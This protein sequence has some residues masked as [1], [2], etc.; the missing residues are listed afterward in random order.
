MSAD[1][2]R[3]WGADAE[4]GAHRGGMDVEGGAHGGGVEAV[5]GQSQTRPAAGMDMSM[6]VDVA[7][8]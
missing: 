6:K 4:G 1:G 2:V 7:R 5:L 3:R 8:C